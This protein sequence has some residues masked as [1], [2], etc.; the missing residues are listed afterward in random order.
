MSAGLIECFQCTTGMSFRIS[1]TRFCTNGFHSFSIPCIQYRATCESVKHFGDPMGRTGCRISVTVVRSLDRSSA[2]KSSS[3][4]IV[5]DCIGAT[6]VFEET[7]LTV[8]FINLWTSFFVYFMAFFLAFLFL[9]FSELLL[10]KDTLEISL[11]SFR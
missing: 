2:D 8:T 10:C 3:L 6:Q 9:C 5:C 1:L 4:G 11:F 7:K